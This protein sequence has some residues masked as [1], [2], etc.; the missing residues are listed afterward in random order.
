MVFLPWLASAGAALTAWGAR[1]G[2]V[3]TAYSAGF[4]GAATIYL[5][6]MR[7][8]RDMVAVLDHSLAS[9]AVRAGGVAVD[10]AGSIAMF[11]PDNLG[12]CVIIVLDAF[13]CRAAYILVIR[14]INQVASAQ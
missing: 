6:C 14:Y 9:G 11:V 13:I 7:L 4:F 2:L 8:L 10:F 12:N 5:A 1:K 3:V